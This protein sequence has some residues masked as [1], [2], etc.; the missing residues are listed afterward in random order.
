[1]LGALVA[2]AGS[3][4]LDLRLVLGRNAQ[5]EPALSDRMLELAGCG[6]A[7]L[8]VRDVHQVAYGVAS[9][10][11]ATSIACVTGASRATT[12]DLL[13]D[14]AVEC[15]TVDYV[16]VLVPLLL[17]AQPEIGRALTEALVARVA[18]RNAKIEAA[19]KN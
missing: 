5:A 9:T 17:D 13:P 4:D 19:R 6:C 18:E 1:M 3:Q 8:N 7:P 14:E 2:A 15:E 16:P 10:E 12:G 11:K